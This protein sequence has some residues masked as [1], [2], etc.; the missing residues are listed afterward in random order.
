MTNDVLPTLEFRIPI[1][2]N[3]KYMRMLHYFVESLRTFGGEIARNAHCVA[4]VGEDEEP[5]DLK[6]Q[7]PWTHN[8]SLDFIWVDREIFR[9][10]T[11]DATGYVRFWVASD[12]DIVA[13]VDVDL[14]FAGDFDD[15]IIDAFRRQCVLGFIAHVSPFEVPEFGETS[16]EHWWRRIFAAAQLPAPKME[17]QHTGWGLMSHNAKHRYCPA[18]Y[19]YGFIVA[20]RILVEKMGKSFVEEI[21][22]IDGIFETWFKSQIANTLIFNRYEMPC[23][24]LSINYNFPLHVPGDAIR[25]LNP[26]PEGKNSLE[27]IKIFHYLGNGEFNKE[28]FVS[29]A[30]LESALNR[31]CMSESSALFREKLTT[32]YNIIN[33]RNEFKY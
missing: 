6:Q 32:I 12:A 26:D 3:E 21:A 27:D 28:D 18:Y 11:Y 17:F 2:P 25:A 14:L 29:S 24:A 33:Q 19:N 5:W 20:P 16:S 9:K 1:S 22:S 30:L 7:Y 31:T 10:D 15:V 23:A 13:L 8:Y 4:V